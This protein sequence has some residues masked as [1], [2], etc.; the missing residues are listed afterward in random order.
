MKRR[1]TTIIVMGFLGII[2]LQEAYGTFSEFARIAPETEGRYGVFLQILPVQGQD[3]KCKIIPPKV[4]QGMSTYLIVCREK[5][6]PKE[7]NF[8]WYI[9]QRDWYRDRDWPDILSVA[10]LLPYGL[11]KYPNSPYVVSPMP[12][13]VI[14]DRSLLE[15]SYL[16][17]DYPTEVSDGGYFYC[18]DLSTYPLPEERTMRVRYSPAQGL[19]PEKGVMRR[20]PSDIIKIGNL[21]YVWY[22]KSRASHGYDATIWYAISPDGH[23]WTEKGEALPRGRRGS[24][25]AQSVFTPNILRVKG[26]YYLFYT[27]VPKPFNNQGNKVTK[28]AIGVAVADSPHGFWEKL[29]DNP[30]LELGDQRRKKFDS[31]RV[32]GACLLVRDGKYWLYY[33]GR[34][35]NDTPAH[36]EMGLAVARQPEGPYERCAHPVVKGGHEV[37][38]WPVGHGVAA[39]MNI[40]PEGIGKTLQYAPD[41]LEFS[42]M[43]DLEQVPR[44]PGAYRPEAFTDSGDG[45]MIEWGLHIG[46]QEGT[47]PFLERF[48]CQWR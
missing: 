22:T 37:L 42:R 30:V 23:T 35:W 14:L 26:K 45:R 20:D 4:Y 29:E 3:G 15:R 13:H 39:M 32:D 1:M 47:L 28:T 48:D 34:R 43:M 33:K 6:P 24:W 44:A 12:N 5:I 41:G 31:M 10:P 16:Y 46:C 38:V 9:W 7:Q 21:Y 27:G 11:D 2:S 25:D 40:G 19:G 17:I 18:I 36:T 8:R